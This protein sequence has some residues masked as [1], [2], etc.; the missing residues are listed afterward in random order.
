MEILILWAIIAFIAGCAGAGKYILSTKAGFWCFLIFGL[1]PGAIMGES[2]DAGSIMVF[3]YAPGTVVLL[4]IIVALGEVTRKNLSTVRNSAKQKYIGYMEKVQLS[5]QARKDHKKKLAGIVATVSIVVL[6]IIGYTNNTPYRELETHI[7]NKTLTEDMCD[8]D[9]EYYDIVT[10]DKG[11]SVIFKKLEVYKQSNDIA[12]AMWLLSV[13]PSTATDEILPDSISVWLLDYAQANGVRTSNKSEDEYYRLTYFELEDY[14]ILVPTT[15]D[16]LNGNCLRTVPNTG[17]DYGRVD[18]DDNESHF[19][20]ADIPYYGMDENYIN[21]TNLGPYD[22][23]ELCRD[24]YALEYDHRSITYYWYDEN[25]SEIFSAYA[26]AG[27]VISTVDKR[28][29]GFKT[30]STSDHIND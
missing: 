17:Q 13:L 24:Y 21:N 3:I 29:G 6:I 28:N 23:R 1:I 2:A 8:W 9:A 11:R 19:H 4:A 15:G 25:G 12:S 18:Y 26:L 16:E 22:E 14:Y 10:S 5:S 27:K 30:D 20:V 7:S